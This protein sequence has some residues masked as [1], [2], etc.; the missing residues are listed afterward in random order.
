MY[1]EFGSSTQQ[2]QAFGQ[3]LMTQ[4]PY[5][6]D[7]TAPQAQADA[8]PT[9]RRVISINGQKYPLPEHVVTNIEKVIGF[10]TKQENSV[11]LS[12]KVLA[13]VAE[14]FGRP[15]FLYLQLTVFISWWVCSRLVEAG[16]L[17]WD[18]PLLSLQ[19][20]GIDVASLLIATGVLL[21][22]TRQ[23]KI[24]EQRSHL[25]LQV[26]LL[27]EQKIAKVIEL[28]EELRT[29]M[30]T[31]KNRYD[32]EATEMQQSTDPQIVLDILQENLEHT[33]ISSPEQ[34]KQETTADPNNSG[35]TVQIDRA[36]NNL[37]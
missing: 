36:D 24:A 31:V 30:P 11:P 20:Q 10:Q 28:M 2:F 9:S 33:D 15:Q 34:E 16:A 21:R 6:N 35:M 1:D 22:Q 4:A 13:K 18:I 29:D 14:A 5:S 25:I 32:W 37:F 3:Q 17:S 7:S 26:N 8:P 27:T 12:E 23:D 19:N